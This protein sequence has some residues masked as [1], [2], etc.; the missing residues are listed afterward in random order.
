MRSL[1]NYRHPGP[2]RVWIGASKTQLMGTFPDDLVDPLDLVD[3]PEPL[4]CS[5]IVV[6]A[7]R[8][9]TFGSDGALA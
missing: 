3:P 2:R 1:L 8:V 5:K 7:E 9:V 4:V 6:F